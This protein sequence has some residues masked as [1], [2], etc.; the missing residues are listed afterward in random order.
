MLLS[1]CGV[2]SSSTLEWACAVGMHT[3]AV[4]GLLEVEWRSCRLFPRSGRG[5]ESCSDLQPA[6]RSRS[7]PTAS[8]RCHCR[9][10]FDVVSVQED[11]ALKSIRP[12]LS[13]RLPCETTFLDSNVVATGAPGSWR[14]RWLLCYTAFVSC[15]VYRCSSGFFRKCTD[16]SS[17]RYSTQTCAT[18]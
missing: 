9:F 15:R 16:K 13:V 10:P 8:S 11:Q 5:P 14:G 1:E 3:A 12:V 6:F 4:L 7:H 2:C 17:R 18:T